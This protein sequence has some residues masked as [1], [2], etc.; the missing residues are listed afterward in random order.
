MSGSRVKS[1]CAEGRLT[2]G[3]IHLAVAKTIRFGQGGETTA[4]DQFKL[5]SSVPPRSSML[6]LRSVREKESMLPNVG[7]FA[8]KGDETSFFQNS[9]SLGSARASG[10]GGMP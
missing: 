3:A 7:R 4:P 6:S 1:A 5:D 8:E 10:F 2:G 9:N